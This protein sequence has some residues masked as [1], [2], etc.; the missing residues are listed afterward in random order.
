MNDS[1]EGVYKRFGKY[2]LL[3][4]VVD[5]GMA[6]LY[7]ARELAENVEKIVADKVVAIKVIKKQFSEDP[8]FKKMFLDEIKIAFGLVHPN[9][10]Q[11]YNYGE[12]SGKIFTVLEYVHGQNLQQINKSLKKKSL[13]F[14]IEMAVYIAAQICQ[15]LDYAHKFTDK[16]SG[17]KLNLVHRDISP[18]NVMLDYD[19]MVKVIDFGIAKAETNTEATQAGTI[20]GKVSYIAPEYLV[21]GGKIDHRYDQFAVGLVLWETLAGRKVFSGENDMAILKK[22]F[23]CK[24]PAPSSFNPNVPKELEAI[25][26]KA[27]SRDP[28][29]RFPDM[30][31]FGRHLTKF[32]HVK[33]PDFTTNDLGQFLQNNFSSE[34]VEAREKLKVFGKIPL[35]PF[36]E[37]LK[38]EIEGRPSSADAPSLPN[39]NLLGQDATTSRKL[40]SGS[41][42]DSAI[43]SSTQRRIFGQSSV[44]DTSDKT[45]SPFIQQMRTKKLE[46]TKSNIQIQDVRKELEKKERGK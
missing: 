42:T 31:Q 34:V 20:K 39:T 21:E 8:N 6:E 14:P 26:A 22:V 40:S 46:Q 24:V 16:L 35:R 44:T 43:G 1:A 29:N 9:I 5:G 3:D 17:K 12:L 30:D 25:L 37:D 32:L 36:C 13:S 27:L 38:A 45:I 23:E 4:H 19:G 10:A 28:N 2:L 15:G 18:H 33:Y 41:N 11:T 7:M